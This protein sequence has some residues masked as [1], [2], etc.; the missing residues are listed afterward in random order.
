MIKLK[1]SYILENWNSHGSYVTVNKRL[2]KINQKRKEK[3]VIWALIK[4]RWVVFAKLRV[5][6]VAGAKNF[7]SVNLV[8]HF[9]NL[10]YLICELM[11]SDV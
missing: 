8:I 9:K 5:V 3:Q 7:I 4:E 10:R 6:V 1:F 2:R 11:K